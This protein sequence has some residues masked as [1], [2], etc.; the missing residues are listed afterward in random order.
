MILGTGVD[1]ADIRRIE[2]ILQKEES[3]FAAK[4][5]SENEV[6]CANEKNE[7]LRAGF[8]AK[9]WAAKEAFVKALGLGVTAGVC[10][11]DISVFNDDKGKPYIK[12]EGK[13]LEVLNKK[14]LENYEVKIHLS[15]SD[16]ANAA[17]AFVIIEAEM[18]SK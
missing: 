8:Y 7:G 9:R 4:Y 18:I 6:A 3:R 11:K 15:L 5:F 1:I 16:D 10:L 17:V 14:N 2:K 12:V 13:T